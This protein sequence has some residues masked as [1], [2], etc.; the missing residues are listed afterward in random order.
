MYHPEN[1]HYTDNNWHRQSVVSE[2]ELQNNCRSRLIIVT[3]YNYVLV[4]LLLLSN[5]ALYRVENMQEA[6]ENI[7]MKASIL[8]N[9]NTLS[10]N[11][12]HFFHM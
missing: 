3:V 8:S 9:L 2:I 11:V 12:V 5:E 7:Y 4:V 10:G 1:S 6:A